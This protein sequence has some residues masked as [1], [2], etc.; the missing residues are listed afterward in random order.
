MATFN[1][2]QVLH[3]V[4]DDKIFGAQDSETDAFR[5]ARFLALKIARRMRSGWQD[6]WR[7]R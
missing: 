6:F 3:C 7:S 5:M 2:K 1:K 4:Q